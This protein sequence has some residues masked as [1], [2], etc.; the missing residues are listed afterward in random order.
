MAVPFDSEELAKLGWRQG[1]ILGPELSRIARQSA[2]ER[3]AVT[4]DDR[5]IVTS[6]D[7]D[8]V[9]P[10]LDKEPVVE[11][12]R[13]AVATANREARQYSGGRNPRALSLAHED[14]TTATVL[15]CSVHDRWTIPRDLLLREEPQ[16]RLADRERKLVAE[17]LA[18]RYIRA[19]FPTTFD[20]RWHTK[21]KAWQR[22]LQRYSEWLQGVYVRLN[23]LDELPENVA[24]TCDFILAV[25]F[26][27]QGGEGW[28]AHREDLEREVRGF[29]DQFKPAIDCSGVTPLGT[30]EITLADLEEYQRFD[31]DWVSFEDDT[32]TTPQTADMRS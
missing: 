16:E 28:P 11:I 18:K 29:W 19:A 30:D 2:P 9:S 15:A 31:S 6:H 10:S 12:L 13:A 26:D 32:P 7:C 24:Y 5:L 4:G 1:S 8:I 27:K 21:R 22:L 17:W 23:T 14:G 3:V 20:R 25:P